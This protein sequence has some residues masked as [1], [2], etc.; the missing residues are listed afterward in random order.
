MDSFSSGGIRI[1]KLSERNFYSWKQKVELVLDHRE[2]DDMIDTVLCP[3]R[4]EDPE[5]LAK[6]LRKGKLARMTI[7]L[8]LSDEMLKNVRYKETALQMWTEI[9][10][11]YQ[12]HTLLNK[13][14][15]R[16]E[17]YTATMRDGEKMLVYINRVR[18]MCN[19]PF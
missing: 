3:H 6:W 17:F 9:C 11:V 13:L 19:R 14:S 16:R 10:N 7:G 8:S 1:E 12:R 15:D 5:Q 2:V 18:Q 4:P